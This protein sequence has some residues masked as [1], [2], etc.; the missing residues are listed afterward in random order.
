MIHVAVFRNSSKFFKKQ[1][2]P[3]SGPKSTIVAFSLSELC[4]PGVWQERGML[5]N[6]GFRRYSPTFVLKSQEKNISPKGSQKSC[7]TVTPFK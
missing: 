6:Q 3:I 7:S 5:R 1:N 2:P 4:Y